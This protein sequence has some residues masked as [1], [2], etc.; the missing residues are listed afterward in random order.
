M[1]IDAS[2]LAKSEPAGITSND[3]KFHVLMP[4]IEY[5]NHIYF[6]LAN[7]E[8]MIIIRSPISY[9]YIFSSK[10]SCDNRLF[11]ACLLDKSDS[12][13]LC[14]FD[15]VSKTSI[16]LSSLEH[17]ILLSVSFTLCSGSPGIVYSQEYSNDVHI[18]DV[19]KKTEIHSFS[20]S[21]PINS[22]ALTGDNNIIIATKCCCAD[23]NTIHVFDSTGHKIEGFSMGIRSDS[24]FLHPL[25]PN[26]IGF[27]SLNLLQSA[28]EETSPPNIKYFTSLIDLA[29]SETIITV[30]G[31]QGAF[32]PCGNKFFVRSVAVDDTWMVFP[33]SLSLE[34]SMTVISPSE[35][36][37]EENEEEIVESCSISDPIHSDDDQS[38][39]SA[40]LAHSAR[41]PDTTS[42]PVVLPQSPTIPSCDVEELEIDDCDHSA[43]ARLSSSSHTTAHDIS[44]LSFSSSTHSDASKTSSMTRKDKD[45]QPTFEEDHSQDDADRMMLGGSTMCGLEHSLSTTSLIQ[46]EEATS[47]P[48]KFLTDSIGFYHTTEEVV[49][50]NCSLQDEMEVDLHANGILIPFDLDNHMFLCYNWN[51]VEKDYDDVVIVVI[52]EDHCIIEGKMNV[53]SLLERRIKRKLERKEKRDKRRQERKEN[54]GCFIDEMEVDLHANGI[55]IPFDL[56]NHMFLCYNWNKVEKDYD[57]VVIVVI[58]EDHCIIE[59]K[60]NVTS[61]LERRIKRKLERK[62]K[63]DKRR[64]E[65]K[66]N[67]GCFI[68]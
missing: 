60:M 58:D 32:S 40:D 9:K 26:I 68:V 33:S 28:T 5:K 13:I 49:L 10:F 47:I 65:R 29:T 27:T 38:D 37:E 25:S 12:I 15:L 57:D 64:Q 7:S 2:K 66:E 36:E 43:V 21:A 44:I 42:F 19:L 61:L 22:M 62:E 55:L 45:S 41:I 24:I 35:Q 50:F 8:T 54:G 39:D 51:K 48:P 56:D 31:R 11:A 1:R 16:V 59:G 63:R 14:C 23:D 34:S 3:G 18:L 4:K 20:V 52:D 6:Y 67:G 30:E 17:S 46:C 53:T